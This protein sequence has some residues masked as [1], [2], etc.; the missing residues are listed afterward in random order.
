MRRVLRLFNIYISCVR[1]II[2]KLLRRNKI[3]IKIIYECIQHF[4]GVVRFSFSSTVRFWCTPL[5]TLRYLNKLMY[6]CWY[7][8]AVQLVCVITSVIIYEIKIRDSNFYR[9]NKCKVPNNSIISFVRYSTAIKHYAQDRS[10]KNIFL[11]GGL[12]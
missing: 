11:G 10:Q 7:L 12:R 1:R 4:V 8:M 9:I 6:F 5:H 2:S 3:K